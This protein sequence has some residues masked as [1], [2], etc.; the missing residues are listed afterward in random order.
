MNL[1]K[2]AQQALAALECLDGYNG[3]VEVGEEIDALRA[4]LAEDVPE[5]NFGNMAQAV[6]PV[7]WAVVGDGKFGKYQLGNHFESEVQ[8]NFKYWG[9]RGYELIPLYAAPPKLKPLT[10]QQ[11]MEIEKRVHFHESPDWPIRFARELERANG[12]GGDE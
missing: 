6:D 8:P 2:A 9:N 1:R 4:A 3:W 12:I 7:A 11:I 5:T 10:E